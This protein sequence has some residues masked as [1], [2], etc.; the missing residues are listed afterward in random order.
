MSNAPRKPRKQLMVFNDPHPLRVDRKVATEIGFLESVILLQIEFHISTTNNLRDGQYW[1]Y[2][3]LAEMKERDFPWLSQSTISRT[4][5][6]LEDMGLINV[7]NFN[8]SRMDR[9]QWF[10]LN[11][12]GIAKLK[13]LSVGEDAPILQNENWEL[14]KEKSILQN[15]KSNLQNGESI[16][17][18]GATIP[19]YSPKESPD[20][21]TEESEKKRAKESFS[22]AAIPENTNPEK[23]RPEAEFIAAVQKLREK[24]RRGS[25]PGGAHPGADEVKR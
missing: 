4:I 19:K 3:T 24:D 20:H 11:Y 16:L 17:R 22:P 10:A 6:S 1:T 8:K 7:G 18:G 21:I 9:T 2:Q 13:S 23:S 5:Q 15:E 25:P 14:R 12:E